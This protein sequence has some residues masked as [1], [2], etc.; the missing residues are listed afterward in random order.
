MK[1]FLFS[2]GC[3]VN[4]Y[5]NDNLRQTFLKLGYEEVV[6][7]DE[8]DIIVLNTCSVT[9]VA[10]KKSRQHVR[11]FRK[12]AP[13]AILVVMGCYTV[14]HYE[15][16]KSIGADIVLGTANRNKIPEYIDTF[17]KNHEF[18]LDM[19][20]T[21]RKEK[22]EEMGQIALTDNTRAYLKIQDGCD[23]YCTYCIIP[24]L[25]GNSRSREIEN[26]LREAKHM[27]E[28]GYKEIVITG[29]HLGAYGKDLGDGSY[30]L[31]N[32]L[33][34]MLAQSPDL[35]RL[36]ISSIEDSE[37]DEKMLN[38]LKGNKEVVSHLHMPLQSGSDGVLKRMHRKY[39][40]AFFMNTLNT[41]RE[42]R[43]DIAITTDVIVGFPGETE[44]EFQETLDFCRRARF[45]EIHVFP[46][47]ARKGTYA[48]TLKDT[49]PEIKKDRVH[50]LLD[51]SKELREEYEKQFYGQELTVLFEDYN[52]KEGLAYGHT[53]NYLLVKV[54][55]NHSK[56]GEIE[57]VLYNDK[58]KAD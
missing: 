5:E 25:R 34:D 49:A 30:R 13:K 42:I 16:A 36:R 19:K 56:H 26:T 15:E 12:A 27:V 8:A 23:N 44:E 4:S 2:L 47:S 3:K 10:D 38:I 39:D 45:A 20:T 54:P 40:C 33:T 21:F 18:I 29:V 43:P 24:T 53:A 11:R 17:S 6:R 57:R 48:A 50:R 28:L 7:E 37:I 52:E 35:F 9:S 32:L 55:S 41:I 51:L 58:T 31:G 22:Y 14:L 1:F 46:Y